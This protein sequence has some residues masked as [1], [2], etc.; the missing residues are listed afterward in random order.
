MKICR[1][2]VDWGNQRAGFSLLEVITVVVLISIVSMATVPAVVGWQRRIILDQ[3]V[4]DLQRQSTEIRSRTVQ[5]GESWQLMLNN[6][7]HEGFRICVADSRQRIQF[8][9][10]PD[11]QYTR[12]TDGASPS[13]EMEFKVVF[14]PDGTVEPTTIRVSDSKGNSRYLM[15]DRLTGSSSVAD[16]LPQQ[17]QG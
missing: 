10:D 7:T 15:F 8:S 6:R 14:F 1:P 13:S 12:I 3:A 5:D 2:D 4:S 16:V 17:T 11:L 9:L